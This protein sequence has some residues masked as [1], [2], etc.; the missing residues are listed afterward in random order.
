MPTAPSHLPESIRI[1]KWLWA[2]R[3]YKTRSQATEAC[4]AGR[5]KISG[6]A[7][8]PSREIHAGD[9]ITVHLGIYSKT[10]RVILP[11]HL[12]VSA[13][14]VPAFMDD[15]TPATEY[16]KLKVQQ[17]MKPEF[18]PRGIGRPTKRQRRLIDRLKK[19]KDFNE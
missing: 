5:V 12:R 10:V 6:Q 4:R 15:L 13:A 11:L 18:R 19:T 8:K 14:L 3:I 7:V 17:D 16:D 9:E 2:V 1:D